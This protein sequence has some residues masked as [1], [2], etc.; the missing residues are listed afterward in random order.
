MSPMG[1]KSKTQELSESLL[2]QH[3]GLSVA[4]HLA[5]TQLVPDPLAPYD[6]QHLS[7]MLDTVANALARVAP[8]HVQ[9]VKGGAPRLLTEADL[10]GARIKRGATLIVL[11]DGRSLSGVSIKRADLRQAIAILKA[12]GIQELT[13]NGKEPEPAKVEEPRDRL[14]ML[15]A[16]LAHIESLLRPPLMPAQFDQANSA[17]V[18]IARNAPQGRISNVAMQ[19][20]SAVHEARSA[21]NGDADA[22]RIHLG[23]ARLRAAI[24]DAEGVSS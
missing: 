15:R 8:L 12:V 16:E 19:L 2:G 6:G 22:E 11:K 7:E 4:A 20:M 3:L 10:E 18:S 24:Q 21:E 1:R 13:R 5:R 17:I 9:D 23:L 14:A